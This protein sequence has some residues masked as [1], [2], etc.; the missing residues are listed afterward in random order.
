MA[1][2]RIAFL[3]LAS[4]AFGCAAPSKSHG[5][6]TLLSERTR[7]SWR[8]ADFAGGAAPEWVNGQLVLPA[9]S[10]LTGALWTGP[11]PTGAYE[12]E[13]EAMRIEGKDIFCGLTF[14]V[15]SSAA[16]LVL[17]GWGGSLCGISSIDSLDAS[18]NSTTR[19]IEFQNG[20]WS[21]VQ[22]RVTAD[23]IEAWLDGE[24]LVD[25]SIEGHRLDTRW[26]MRHA[27]PLGVASYQTRAAVR[28][29]RWRPLL[30]SEAMR[31]APAP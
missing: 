28:G 12:I 10:T 13:L 8:T 19:V 3:S 24:S 7:G 11:L 26:E 1:L 23:R 21:R 22:V 29:L 18:E 2:A 5:W 17:G 27:K 16:S 4:A 14:P 9:G 20:T 15:G 31:P 6:Q 25:V 30:E